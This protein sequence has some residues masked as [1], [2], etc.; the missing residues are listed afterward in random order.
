MTSSRE[1][2]EVLE[3]DRAI[4]NGELNTFWQIYTNPTKLKIGEKKDNSVKKR[5]KDMNKH[6]T[7]EDMQ[8]TDKREKC[9]NLI[10]HQERQIKTTMSYY[11]NENR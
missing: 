3:Q 8:L 10:S 7:K 2:P 6:F 11:T 9:F 5:V 4:C 1:I